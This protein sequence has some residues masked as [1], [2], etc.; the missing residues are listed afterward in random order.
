MQL[1]DLQL[2]LKLANFPAFDLVL[3]EYIRIAVGHCRILGHALGNQRGAWRV[4]T[5][6][7]CALRLPC[8]VW[9]ATLR[10]GRRGLPFIL[11][12][13]DLI[14]NI[15]IGVRDARATIDRLTCSAARCFASSL[16]ARFLQ[17]PVPRT[18]RYEFL[19]VGQFFPHRDSWRVSRIGI[20]VVGRVDVADR[21][22]SCSLR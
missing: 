15:V 5:R 16:E 18:R 20:G 2:L 13:F 10:D 4:I 12:P 21:A 11:G 22:V 6:W 17:S 19:Q 7:R 1:K 8:V 3:L 9:R 14:A